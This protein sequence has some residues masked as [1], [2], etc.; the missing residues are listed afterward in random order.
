[1]CCKMKKTCKI[2]AFTVLIGLIGSSNF[3]KASADRRFNIQGKKT[4]VTANVDRVREKAK[5]DF[6]YEKLLDHKEGVA[7]VPIENNSCGGCFMNVTPQMINAV[8]MNEEVVVCET[9][10]RILYIKDD[11]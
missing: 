3:G 6:R 2:I 11:L 4:I 7:I 8:K 10:S 1:M 5:G 9:C